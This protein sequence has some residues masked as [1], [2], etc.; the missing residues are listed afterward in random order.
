M[1][2]NVLIL[3][4]GGREHAIAEK[5]SQSNLLQQLFIMPGN[6]GTM[7]FALQIP[8]DIM[9]PVQVISQIENFNIDI[10]ICGP[11]LPL[12]AGLMDAISVSSISH[13]PILV[14]PNQQGAQLESSKA[15][16]KDFMSRHQIP[17]AAFKSFIKV[18][19]SEAI[20]F[21]KSLTPPIV[22]KASGLAAGKGVVICPDHESAILELKFMFEG[23]FGTSSET[24]VIEE[25][26]DGKEFSVFIL[27]NGNQYALLPEAKDYKRIGIADTGLNTGGM[28]AVS[29]VSFISSAVMDEVKKSIIEKTLDGLIKENIPYQGF[30]FFGLIEVRGQAFVIEYN[31][32]LGDPE[33]EVILPRLKNDLI[34]LIIAMDEKKLDSIPIETDSRTAVTIMLV[35]GGYPGDYE[36]GK[37]IKLPDVLPEDSVIFHAGTLWEDQILKTNGGR[38]LSVTSLNN[39]LDS[40][41]TNSLQLA[42][43]I[44][45]DGKYFRND[46]GFDFKH[47]I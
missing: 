31:C 43:K 21:I 29:P 41:L 18:Q 28:G 36:K 38:V 23:K 16:S 22:I 8:G 46:I 45:F 11:E 1:K 20:S 25:F 4:S 30:L 17:T 44:Q 9:D 10:V 6:P 40:A 7:D 13:K 27:C 33:T 39:S 12:A 47:P 24:I 14:G 26:L 35:S 37:E 19:E 3:G 42:E 5:I 2:K 15:F 34:E 32:R